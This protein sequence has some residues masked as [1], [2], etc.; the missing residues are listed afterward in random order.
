MGYLYFTLLWE[1]NEL[2]QH[3]QT[4]EGEDEVF[5]T[6]LRCGDFEVSLE[7]AESDSNAEKITLFATHI[8][9]GCVSLAEVLIE[10]RENIQNKA[11]LEFGAA[12]G[13]P[14]IITAKCGAAKVCASDYPSQEVIDT[15]K[16]NVKRN[17]MDTLVTVVPHIWGSAV[18][19]LLAENCGRK[20]DVI[21]MAECVWRHDCHDDLLLSV[22][23]CLKEEGRLLMTYSH[24][25]PGCEDADDAFCRKAEQ[26]GFFLREKR[27]LRIPHQWKPDEMKSLFFCDF[28]FQPKVFEAPH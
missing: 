15:L 25:V 21:V 23:S 12:S 26:C 4:E 9:K 5:L 16:R 27:I 10:L 11:V 20:Y 18:S 2:L 1:M 3:N 28:T 19:S 7:T 17:E 14:S 8:W 22:R 13:L 24:H 6:T